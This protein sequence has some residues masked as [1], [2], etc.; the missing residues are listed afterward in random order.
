MN[1]IVKRHYPVEKL[2]A[3]LKVGVGSAATVTVTLELETDE[4]TPSSRS[5]QDIKA[6]L[7]AAKARGDL[8][9]VTPQEAVARVRALRDEW[10]D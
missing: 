10:D 8:R 9:T 2:P 1:V 4:A 7:D 6:G 3:D 5:L